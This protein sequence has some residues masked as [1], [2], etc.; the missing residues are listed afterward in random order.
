MS[1]TCCGTSR[2]PSS[3]SPGRALLYAPEVKLT[4]AAFGVDFLDRA[5]SAF[6]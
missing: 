1:L 3:L 4:G 2:S 6:P 5:Y